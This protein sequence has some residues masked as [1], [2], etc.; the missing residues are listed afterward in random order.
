MYGYI[1]GRSHGPD[2]DRF[3][4]L[5]KSLIALLL[6]AL[7]AGLLWW[8]LWRPPRSLDD[9]FLTGPRGPVCLRLLAVSDRSG[10][11]SDFAPARERAV[12]RFLGWAQ[13]NLRPDD[14]VGVLEFASE[15]AWSRV[16]TPVS[17]GVAAY[18]NSDSNVG[19]GTELAPVVGALKALPRSQCDT[20]VVLLS[21]AQI[22]G[23]PADETAARGLLQ[24]LD[25]HDLALLVP[26]RRIQVYPG[27]LQLF[28]YATPEAFDGL[29]DA[30]TGV[31]L[32]Q[33][34]ALLTGQGLSTQR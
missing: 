23:L 34:V 19:G 18:R 33:Q 21:D 29:D 27:W 3:V 7:V 11:M 15:A 14:E 20:A 6:V 2:T 4:Q 22:N 25:V 17:A 12:Q 32:A 26:D 9:V 13:A 10:S 30:Q 31:V 5:A 28:P 24:D 8:K 16:P 1:E